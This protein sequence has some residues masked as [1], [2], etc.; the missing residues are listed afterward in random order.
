M[1][2][3]SL[4]STGWPPGPD[5]ASHES[6]PVSKEPISVFI[7]GAGSRG[8]TVY[9][10]FIKENPTLARVVAVA[11]PVESRRQAL[12]T[13]HDIP[14]HNRFTSWE[15]L[16]SKPVADVAVIATGD[17][18]HVEPAVRF[19]DQGYHVLLE[20]PMAPDLE[21]CRKI[22]EAAER[23]SGMSAV[24]HVLR[25]TPY[26]RKLRQL[27]EQG[28]VGRILTIRHF[29][30]VNYWHFAHSFV[31]G[32]WR[33]SQTSSVFILTKC[34]HDMDILWYLM[35][36]RPVAV[37]S[38]GAL[39]YFRPE[40]AP[41]E[42]AVRCLDCTLNETCTY[43]AT[44]FYGDML[45]SQRHWWPLDVVTGEFTPE[46]LE[47][48]LRKGPYGRCVYHCD[49]DVCDHQVVNFEFETGATASFVATAFSEVPARQTEVLGS[50]GSLSGDGCEIV[51]K[52]FQSGTTERIA[53][54]SSGNHLGG[55]EAMLQEFFG[56]VQAGDPGR[57]S[58]SPAISLLSH[59]MALLA[60]RSRI[61]RRVV[62]LG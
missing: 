48:Q 18:C 34:C 10:Q 59:Q 6:G 32:N 41:A 58:T 21:G 61:E 56:A 38:F 47:E 17:R 51:F 44:K 3:I 25:Y 19:L 20:K 16:P 33:N 49:N 4:N 31:R 37:H 43:S 60:E 12:A 5:S 11:D 52:N 15:E 13:E 53:V 45:K 54:E 57:L 23:A 1:D 29:E 30:P 14:E 46:A 50:N 2:F 36:E 39:S 22:V 62:E 42:A 35:G 40:S 27:I 8:H 7:C 9:G 24:C 55:D 28:A 26:F